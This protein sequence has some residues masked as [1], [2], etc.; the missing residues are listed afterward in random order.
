MTT[1]KDASGTPNYVGLVD[2]GS[3]PVKR[4]DFGQSSKQGYSLPDIIEK[5]DGRFVLYDEVLPLLKIIQLQEAL[6]AKQAAEMKALTDDSA[7]YRWL[8]TFGVS[9]LPEAQSILQCQMVDGS[10]DTA[11]HMDRAIKKATGGL[12]GRPKTQPKD[13]GHYFPPTPGPYG[14]CMGCMQHCQ[15]GFCA[16]K[17]GGQT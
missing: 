1:K 9:G 10:L 7:S 8:R 16:K 14:N 17:M 4:Y 2:S 12:G 6:L 5:A 15:V 11:D 13:D 3:A